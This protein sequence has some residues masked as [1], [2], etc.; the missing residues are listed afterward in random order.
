M[1]KLFIL[2]MLLFISSCA[3]VENPSDP[4]KPEKKVVQPVIA[5]IITAYESNDLKKIKTFS[6]KDIATQFFKFY[7]KKEYEKFLIFYNT[8]MKEALPSEKTINVFNSFYKTCGNLSDI[9]ESEKVGKSAFFNIVKCKKGKNIKFSFYIDDDNRLA[10]LW[11]TE[12]IQFPKITEQTTVV[13]IAKAVTGKEGKAG[14]VIGT[15]LNGAEKTYAFGYNSIKE[16]TPV[17]K[18]MIFEIGSIT[19]TFTAAIMLQLEAEGKLNV[20][21]P[22][23]KYLPEN[24]KMPI[25]EGDDTQITFKHIS[26][27]TS[28]LPRMPSDFKEYEKD[29]LN[30]YADYPVEAIYKFISNYK[31]IRKPGETY[32]YSNLAMGFLGNILVKIDGKKNYEELIQERIFKPLGM[33]SSTTELSKVD[34]KLLAKPHNSGKEVKNWDL[35]SFAGAGA[36][37]SNAHDMLKYIKALIENTHPKI[38][39][40]K[41][42]TELHLSEKD[43]YACFNWG[44]THYPHGTRYGHRGAT[45]GYSTHIH[46]DRENKAGVIILTNYTENFENAARKILQILLKKYDE[47][48]NE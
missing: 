3:S 45:G 25:Y 7:N 4:V 11:L 42:F 5:E 38:L 12:P 34:K 8:N 26:S 19:K 31:M 9:G 22:I 21:D 32:E 10:G 16:K 28:G 35:P 6:N 47:P 40:E 43:T 2:I 18:D 36:I 29:I 17:N 15:Y 30:P 44:K 46:I 23:A 37:K 13:D 24:V 14:I 27:H 39:P 33:I 1:K 20:D 41:M 48:G